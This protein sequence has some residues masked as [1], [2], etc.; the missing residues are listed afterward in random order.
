MFSWILSIISP[1]CL[2]KNDISCIS[3]KFSSTDFYSL[4]ICSFFSKI[5]STRYFNLSEALPKVFC[6]INWSNPCFFLAIFSAYESDSYGARAFILFKDVLIEYFY[7]SIWTFWV[8]EIIW[9]T[10]WIIYC[11]WY[12]WEWVSG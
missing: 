1:C 5:S 10:Y 8:S 9:L 12:I 11:F 4:I 7:I 6:M 2:T 3:L